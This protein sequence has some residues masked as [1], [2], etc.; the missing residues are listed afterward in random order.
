[1]AE[2]NPAQL[3]RILGTESYK[4]TPATLAMRTSRGKWKAA[5]HLLYLSGIIAHALH[6]GNARLIISMPPRHG[7]SKLGSVRT[8]VWQFDRFPDRQIGVTS[9]GADLATEFSEEVRNII[10]E[11]NDPEQG[12]HLLD[13]KLNTTKVNNWTTTQ[14]GR[15][16]A[17][18]VGGTLYG[19]GVHDLLVD[20]YYKNV[21]EAES[22]AYRDKVFE[23]FGVIAATRIEPGGS[24][25][26]ISTRWHPDDLSGR[27]LAMPDS[28]WT[29][30]RIPGIA[31]ENDVLGRQ[32]GEALW[33]E[34][35]DV[36]ALLSWKATMGGY[37]FDS[38]VQQKPR[39]SRS[40]IFQE[41]WV[42]ILDELPA[43]IASGDW[44]E[45]RSWDFA[46]TEGGGDY[47]VGTKMFAN[48]KTL[49][50]IIADV[51]RDQ[52]S[53]GKVEELVL[54]T[55]EQDGKAC[56]ISLEQEPGSA[57]KA[58]MAT[59]KKL[60]R[61]FTVAEVKDTGSKFIKAQ[62]LMAACEHG[63]VSLLRGDWN[64]KWYDEFGKFPDGDND[65]QVDSA[66]QAFN[67]LFTTRKSAGTFGRLIPG[68]NTGIII[69]S[70]AIVSAIGG[71]P[72]RAMFSSTWGRR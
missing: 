11:D 50:V 44:V 49:R 65:D 37:F 5:R 66:S 12:E 27:L 21:E 52:L 22:Q 43:D 32:P 15:M 18:G 13:V 16:Y 17:V 71:K 28:P 34:R 3:Q 48:K 45:V 55:A 46:G 54:D 6:K 42:P 1:M 64:G 19:R 60:L 38:I 8:P 10:M 56:P 35:Y 33:P 68:A 40:S 70:P 61:A 9:Y 25:I 36:P 31:E 47:T 62:P 51:R 7:K 57:G 26:I 72:G 41:H 29:E 67:K 39:K 58:M 2:I 63:R 14:G 30:I 59:Y 69:P 24:I 23:W 53:P 4:L 20:D